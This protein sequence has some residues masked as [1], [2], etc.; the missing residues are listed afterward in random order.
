MFKLVWFWL[1]VLLLGSRYRRTQ[2]FHALTTILDYTLNNP[3][4]LT[5]Y[6]TASR[7][8]SKVLETV[9]GIYC[10]LMGVLLKLTSVRMVCGRRENL[11]NL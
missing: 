5:K 2:A 10:S 9:T 4:T 11:I 7:I 1:L 8:S 3:D 6:N